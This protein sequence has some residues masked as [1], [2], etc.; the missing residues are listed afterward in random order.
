MDGIFVVDKPA[1]MTS[2][3]VI[4]RLRK[5]YNQKKFGHTGTLDPNATG[6]LVV[7]AGKA[8]KLLP[9]LSD[10]SKQY[11][12]AM[13]LGYSTTTED[14]WGEVTERKPVNPDFDFDSL[15]VGF[16][17]SQKQRVPDTS[18]KKVNGKKLLEYQREGKEVPEVFQDITI[19]RI[20]SL[21]ATP[22]QPYRFLVDCSS[23]TY[24][25]ALIRDL[26]LK[27]GNLGVMSDLRRTR[28][29][30]FSIDQ[31]QSLDEELT[32]L[33]MHTVLDLPKIEIDDISEIK[34]GKPV[35]LP[36]A[37]GKPL[38]ALLYKGDLAAL[39]KHKQEDLYLCER[40][41]LG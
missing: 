11:E 16:Q 25:R 7:L 37:Q 29:G 40:G 34:D 2:F 31:A 33:P 9:Y 1:G 39:Y 21:P 32:L 23:G 4:S 22:D 15:L 38:V 36:Q 17:G 19:E 13:T 18:A 24:I 5:R 12:A 8:A 3:D 27:S 35:K 28:V 30:P 26:A 10:T 14:I 20:Q 6:V 41:F